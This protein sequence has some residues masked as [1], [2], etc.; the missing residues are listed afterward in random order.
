MKSTEKNEKKSFDTYLSLL[1]LG[2]LM[3]RTS[4][5]SKFNVAEVHSANFLDHL[6]FSPL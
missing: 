4:R 5:C 6:I 1:Q 3:R 2:N